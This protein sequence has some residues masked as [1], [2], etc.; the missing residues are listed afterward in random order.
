MLEGWAFTCSKWFS[1]GRT[2][3]AIYINIYIYI[4]TWIF[5]VCKKCAFSPKKCQKNRNV[6]YL[7]DP[8]VHNLRKS[9]FFFLGD[10][11]VPM[12]PIEVG[13][14]LQGLGSG[15]WWVGSD[16]LFPFGANSLFSRWMLVL[17]RVLYPN[18]LLSNDSNDHLGCLK[19]PFQRS[20]GHFGRSWKTCKRI[21]SEPMDRNSD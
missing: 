8:G 9:V 1:S 6:T 12:I 4:H 14:S 10:T 3:V 5:Q 19:W 21:R 7:E 13:F 20:N 2:V 17:G 16:E 11:I 18:Q 15:N